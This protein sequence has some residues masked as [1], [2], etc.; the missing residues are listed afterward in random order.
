MGLGIP[1]VA[2]RLGPILDVHADGRT[3]VL[4]EPLNDQQMQEAI[5]ELV[6][7]AERRADVA[8]HALAKLQRDHSWAQNA[9][10]ILRAAG[11][12]ERA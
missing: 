11:L 9:R 2:P 7:S 1:V 10:Q 5:L 4:F 8:R 3:A 12:E 6:N